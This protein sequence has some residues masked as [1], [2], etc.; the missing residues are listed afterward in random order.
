MISREER[1]EGQCGSSVELNEAIWLW[2]YNI[3]CFVTISGFNPY[4]WWAQLAP[5]HPV[6]WGGGNFD[7]VV[8][9]NFAPTFYFLFF[10]WINLNK[11]LPIFQSAPLSKKLVPYFYFPLQIYTLNKT[12]SLE[13]KRSQKWRGKRESEIGGT[14][15]QNWGEAA[16]DYDYRFGE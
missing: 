4:T 3:Q 10:H 1:E 8:D 14:S 2:A 7:K 15:A 13:R 6:K 9:Q 12:F 16:P 5:T 11:T